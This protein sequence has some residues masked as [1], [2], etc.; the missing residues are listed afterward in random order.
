[1]RGLV[2][3]VQRGALHDGPGVRTTVFLKGC[4]L[5]CAWCHNPESWHSVAELAFDQEKC[6]DCLACLQDCL[7]GAHQEKDGRH[8]YDRRHCLACGSCVAS[9]D[10]GGLVLFGREMT[11]PEVMAIVERDQ[12]FYS[13]SG[14]GLTVSGGEP[15]SQPLFTLELLRAAKVRAIPTC[16]D[17]S[18]EGRA[19]D[20]QSLLPFVDLV[21]FDYKATGTVRHRE[22]TG[23]DGTRILANLDEVLASGVRL[24]LRAP[25]VPGVNDDDAHLD[26]IAG[27]AAGGGVEVVE[28]MP[29][30]AFG[31]D[32]RL[33]LG[34]HGGPG[35][36]SATRDQAQ[37]WLDALAERGC[38][39][40]LG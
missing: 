33:R 5:R 11:V 23:S 16:L 39:A 2:F 31:S 19:Q 18:G 3:D 7:G 20:L 1:M 22:L 6:T 4:P 27:I 9:C 14:G 37:R 26:A 35:W 32:K 17:T 10:P 29:Y 21:L 28:V 38:V 30:H 40:R 15:L 24:V 12:P 25:L 34:R 36:P 13:K 8:V